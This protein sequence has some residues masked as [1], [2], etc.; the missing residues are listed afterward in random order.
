MN[1]A[2]RMRVARW[3]DRNGDRSLR[4]AVRCVDFDTVPDILSAGTI[5]TMTIPSAANPIDAESGRLRDGLGDLPT[6]SG[7]WWRRGNL[8]GTESFLV[9]A[10][11]GTCWSAV[12]NAGEELHVVDQEDVEAAV[13][14]LELLKTSFLQIGD[15]VVHERLARQVTR[16]ELG[17]LGADVVGDRLEEV[18]FPRPVEP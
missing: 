3:L 9:R 15:E 10:A 12:A 16:A 6:G 7:N 5:A 4:F 13:A 17:R 18:G 2:Q 11:D 8:P 14:A 1:V